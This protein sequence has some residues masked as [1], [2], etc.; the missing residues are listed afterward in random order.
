MSQL[1]GLKISDVSPVS[2]SII[3]QTD[4]ILDDEKE[5]ASNYSNITLDSIKSDDSETKD[6]EETKEKFV[7]ESEEEKLF[8]QKAVDT[9]EVQKEIKEIK[10]PKKSTYSNITLES[11]QNVDTS[12]IEQEENKKNQLK[13][14]IFLNQSQNLKEEDENSF[15]RLHPAGEIAEDMPEVFQQEFFSMLLD[16]YSE[17][18]IAMMS[19]ELTDAIMPLQ[20]MGELSVAQSGRNIIQELWRVSSWMSPFSGGDKWWNGFGKS[21]F[22]NQEAYDFRE[23]LP[24]LVTSG[25]VL[26]KTVQLATEFFIPAGYLTKGTKLYSQLTTGVKDIAKWKGKFSR[27]EDIGAFAVG[28]GAV[29]MALVNPNDAN[30]AAMIQQHK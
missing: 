18:E 27:G 26:D 12:D 21:K 25:S 2:K 1:E 13:D 5:I 19:G 15:F 3:D 23:E 7:K 8:E 17:E 20:F 24:S 29:D 28:F 6:F 22:N 9:P 4:N 30:L 14:L 11:I 10:E 16:N